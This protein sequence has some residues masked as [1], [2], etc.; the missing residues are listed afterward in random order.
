MR[1]ELQNT[2]VALRGEHSPLSAAALDALRT[3]GATVE[4]VAPMP[5]IL[6]VSLPLLPVVG[7]DPAPLLKAARRTGDAMFARGSGRILFLVSA[8]AGMPMRRHPDFSVAMAGVLATVRTMAMQL[9]P[10]VLVNAVGVGAVGEPLL[11]GDAAM[12]GHASVKR[13]GSAA[14]VTDTVLFFC[15]PLNTYTTGQMLS[16]DGGWSAGYGRNF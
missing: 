16:V 6:L 7:Y 2:F 11:A 5:D 12:L 9:G 3:N 10:K 13:P 8:A 4:T 1:I 14:E 15:D